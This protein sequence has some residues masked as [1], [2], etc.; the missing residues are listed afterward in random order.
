MLGN[1]SAD[2]GQDGVML[3]FNAHSNPSCSN[4]SGLTR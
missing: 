1:A 3:T 2:E 4:T